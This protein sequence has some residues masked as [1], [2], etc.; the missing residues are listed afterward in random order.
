MSSFA[1]SGGTFTPTFFSSAASCFY[2]AVLLLKALF[3]GPERKRVATSQIEIDHEAALQR[4]DEE[5]RRLDAELA[6]V[7]AQQ[8]SL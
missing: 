4:D 3:G 2:A 5:L 7:M 1:S 8:K 6:R